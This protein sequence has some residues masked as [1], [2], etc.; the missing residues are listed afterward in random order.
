MIMILS[1][2]HR[3]REHPRISRRDSLSRLELGLPLA[4]R[5]YWITTVILSGKKWSCRHLDSISFE[6]ALL[7]LSLVHPSILYLFKY[8]G[9]SRLTCCFWTRFSYFNQSS[10]ERMVSNFNRARWLINRFDSLFLSSAALLWVSYSSLSSFLGG[11]ALLHPSYRSKLL[12]Q[13]LDVFFIRC[14]FTLLT[15]PKVIY[16]CCSHA[17]AFWG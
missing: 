5:V 13:S 15:I 3:S 2:S 7:L 17:M 6:S 1:L 4:C 16:L 11:S 8:S 12:V 14:S 10:W 9:T